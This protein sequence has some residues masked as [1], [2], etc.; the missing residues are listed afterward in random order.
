[1]KRRTGSSAASGSGTAL[2][3]YQRLESLGLWR[4]TGDGQRREVVVLM[5]EATLVLS[6]PRSGSALSHWSLPAV[7]RL[8]PG[9]QPAVF[10]PG[11]D[12]PESVEIDDETML[13]ALKMV[14]SA[15]RAD[16]PHPGRLRFA[17]IG[18]AVVGFLGLVTLVLPRILISHTVAV[19]PPSK[20]VEIGMRALD[21]VIRLT[22]AP[23]SGELGLPALAALSDRVFGE[24]NTPILYVLPEGLSRPAHLPG[25]VIL[26]PGSLIDQ[27]A[28]D[29]LAGAALTEGIKAGL[30]DPMRAILDHAGL[31]PTFD[32]LVSGELPAAALEGFGEAFIREEHDL[33]PLPRLQSA[34]E[35]AQVP[36]TPYANW[37]A[38]SGAISATEAAE[39][40]AADPFQGRISSPLLPDDDW[41][42]LQSVCNG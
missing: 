24:A 29:A 32:L 13:A 34:F 11:E 35:A 36:L 15:V 3:K 18:G 8:N 30:A 38:A 40:V 37:L 10:S 21:D 12:S 19:V 41:I 5:G 42:A 33:P 2:S 1:M 39:L 28:P 14:N 31:K 9:Q 25:G 6:D 17:L 22:G 27:D 16:S 26:L 7:R 20:Q 4:D 23:C